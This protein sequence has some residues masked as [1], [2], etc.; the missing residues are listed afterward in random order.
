MFTLFKHIYFSAI[1]IVES[2][3]KCHLSI[4]KCLNKTFIAIGNTNNPR[5]I[6]S[7]QNFRTQLFK[8]IA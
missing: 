4:L 8:S 3:K 7:A 6:T 5:Q 2:A 1:E